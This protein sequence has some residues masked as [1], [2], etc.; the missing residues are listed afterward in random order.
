LKVTSKADDALGGHH[1]LSV[2]LLESLEQLTQY[3]SKIAVMQAR[4]VSETL[5]ANYIPSS[6]QTLAAENI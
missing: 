4:A 2:S 5:L 1:A 6:H 3:T